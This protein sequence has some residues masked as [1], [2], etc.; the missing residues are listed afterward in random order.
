MLPK[1]GS[2]VQLSNANAS[3][4]EGSLPPTPLSLQEKGCTRS[5]GIFLANVL[6]KKTSQLI[7]TL[8]APKRKGAQSEEGGGGDAAAAAAA[9]ASLARMEITAS[10]MVAAK[11]LVSWL[12]RIPS[13]LMGDY[14]SFRQDILKFTRDLS[15]ILVSGVA[16][17][18]YEFTAVVV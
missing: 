6:A 11:S 2:C 4:Y 14:H 3:V 15:S 12:D 17:E 7:T 8:A 9:A 10:V 5:S 16:F 13:G 1:E 18:D